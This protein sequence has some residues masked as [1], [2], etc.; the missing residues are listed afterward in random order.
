M[1]DCGGF[2]GFL[3]A[4]MMGNSQLISAWKYRSEFLQR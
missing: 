4:I 3:E 2:G 1:K